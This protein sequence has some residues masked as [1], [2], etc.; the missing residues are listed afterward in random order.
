MFNA[1]VTSTYNLAVRIMNLKLRFTEKSGKRQV[2]VSQEDL[3]KLNTT[4]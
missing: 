1:V 2:N 4:E 3:V